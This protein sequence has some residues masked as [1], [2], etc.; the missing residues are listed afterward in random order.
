QRHDETPGAIEGL[1]RT[2]HRSQAGGFPAC[3]QGVSGDTI[4]FRGILRDHGRGHPSTP[5]AAAMKPRLI[6][7]SASPR[8]QQLLAEAGYP[9]A[10][11]VSGVE[12]L[13]PDPSISPADYAAHLAWR[14]AAVVARRRGAGL[15][16]GADTVC[17]VAGE[18]LNKP[19]DRQDAE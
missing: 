9:F 13:D 19:R 7:A 3:W 15:I 11:E 12:E 4:G 18:I 5:T 1:G 16:L 10:V 6:L 17:A 8:R 14:K 2:A